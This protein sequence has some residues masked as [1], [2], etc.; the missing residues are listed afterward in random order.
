MRLFLQRL[1]VIPKKY[2][3]AS[4]DEAIFIAV[5]GLSPSEGLSRRFLCRRFPAPFPEL[6]QSCRYSGSCQSR[7]S[8]PHRS[9]AS[10]CR[11]HS[12]SVVRRHL[13]RLPAMCLQSGYRQT[14]TGYIF[15]ASCTRSMTTWGSECRRLRSVL[16]QDRLRTGLTRSRML[17]QSDSLHPV[18]SRPIAMPAPAR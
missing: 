1:K 18:W 16:R 15:S 4:P 17:R 14:P 8:F 13:D 9:R 12:G 3:M 6:N 7:Y 5:E 10:R 2:E 11:S